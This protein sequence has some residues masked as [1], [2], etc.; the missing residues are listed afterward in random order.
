MNAKRGDIFIAHLSPVI[1]SEQ[2]G[3]RPIL[4]LQNDLGNKYSTTVIA[5]P[6]TRSKNKSNLSTHVQLENV[7]Q[8]DQN[9]TVLMEQIRTIDKKRL[10]RRIAHV[11]DQTMQKV[12]MAL[13]ISIGLRGHTQYAL[14]AGG[15]GG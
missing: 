11:D 5:A 14:A 12:N 9:S 6:I 3:T 10:K 8:L 7:P 1:G 2:G 4:I 15:E 13:C